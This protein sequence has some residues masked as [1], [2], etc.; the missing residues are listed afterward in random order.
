MKT[1]RYLTYLSTA[2]CFFMTIKML[3]LDSF[4]DHEYFRQQKF[5]T[6]LC[7]S[8]LIILLITRRALERK[9]TSDKWTNAS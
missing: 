4:V 8:L 9:H 1:L 2:S 7:Y 6:A 3:M 5:L